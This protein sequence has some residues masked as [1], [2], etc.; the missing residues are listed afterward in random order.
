M[1]SRD[2]VEAWDALPKVAQKSILGTLE[3]CGYTQTVDVFTCANCDIVKQ[4]EFAFDP[5][6]TDGD[7]LA[8]K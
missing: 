1:A 3:L 7:C 4:C 5:Y 6:N 2:A 8:D